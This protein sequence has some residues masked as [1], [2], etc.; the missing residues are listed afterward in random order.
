MTTDGDDEISNDDGDDHHIDY[1][2]DDHD[3]KKASR[4]AANQ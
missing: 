2:G 1:D 3:D 4:T